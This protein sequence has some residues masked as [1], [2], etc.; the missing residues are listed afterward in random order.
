VN[1]DTNRWPP[2][3]ILSGVAKYDPLGLY[4]EAGNE[5]NLASMASCP[6]QKDHL[7]GQNQSHAYY[8]LR[9]GHCW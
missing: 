4:D 1:A 6:D 2:I 3:E 7:A 8:Y 9:N 5:K